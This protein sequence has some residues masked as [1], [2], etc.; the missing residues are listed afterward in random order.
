VGRAATKLTVVTSRYTLGAATQI[1]LLEGAPAKAIGPPSSAFPLQ[2][3]LPSFLVTRHQSEVCTLLGWVYS[4]FG[5]PIHPITG[6]PSLLP[7]SSARCVFSF[8]C[9]RATTP[10]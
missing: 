3:S 7:T 10:H 1:V 8:P 5:D 6:W 2:G 9:G 4:P